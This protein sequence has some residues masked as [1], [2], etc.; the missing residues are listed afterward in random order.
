MLASEGLERTIV[1]HSE[2]V[3]GLSQ[4]QKLLSQNQSFSL[5]QIYATR[6]VPQKILSDIQELLDRTMITVMNPN[7]SH[8]VLDR[9]GPLKLDGLIF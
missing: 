9:V 1:D 6:A 2:A 7:K 5:Y 3:F 8:F 4:P